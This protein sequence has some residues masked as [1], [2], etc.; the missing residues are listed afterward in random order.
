M[1]QFGEFHYKP[2]VRLRLGVL[3]CMSKLFQFIGIDVRQIQTNQN[4]QCMLYHVFGVGCINL[5]DLLYAYPLKY[6]Q[7]TQ[8]ISNFKFDMH[9]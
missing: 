8:F 1:Q 6:Q 3:D 2:K 9:A 5:T 4:S 7:N